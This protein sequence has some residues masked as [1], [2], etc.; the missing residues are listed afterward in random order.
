MNWNP[1]SGSQASLPTFVWDQIA[2]GTQ[3][4][5]NRAWAGALVLIALV[6]LLYLGARVVARLFAPQEVVN[7]SET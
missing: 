2:S 1:F 7:G 5:L 6:M 3:A 4:S